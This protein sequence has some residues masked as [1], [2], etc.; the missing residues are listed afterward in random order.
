MAKALDTN[1]RVANS[2]PTG[3]SVGFSDPTSLRSSRLRVENQLK[4]IGPNWVSEVKGKNCN[5]KK[6]ILTYP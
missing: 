3:P 4:G 6:L 2:N 5:R 1:W